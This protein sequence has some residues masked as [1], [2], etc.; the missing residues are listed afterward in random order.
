MHEIGL[1]AVVLCVLVL[2]CGWLAWRLSTG[3]R[4]VMRE[5][6]PRNQLSWR[7]SRSTAL[8][9]AKPLLLPSGDDATPPPLSPNFTVETTAPETTTG[10]FSAQLKDPVLWAAAADSA[11]AGMSILES[12]LKID[13][14][15]L[16]AI[17]F[18]TAQDLHGLADIHSY[19]DAHFSTVASQSAD[20]WFDRLTGYVAEQKAAT[21]FEQA[22]H[23]VQ[24]AP[25]SNQPVW[26]LL[27]DGHPVQIKEHL[28]G[29]KDFAVA[30][31]DIPVYTNLSD[32]AA[33]H[34]HSVHGLSVLDKDSIH[35]ATSNTIDGLD[36]TFD[37]GFHFP[38]I[39]L[40]FSAYRE[41][42]LLVAE[43]TTFE[44]ALVHVGMDVAAVGGGA[45]A[46][47]KLGALAGT[48]VPGP[49][50]VIGALLGS[51]VGGISGK[52][53]ST[54]ARRIPFYAARQKYNETIESA[55]QAIDGE[56]ANSQARVRELQQ[57]YQARFEAFRRRAESEARESI[58]AGLSAYERALVEFYEEFPRYLRD[59][60][61]QL[62]TEERDVLSTL[63][64]SGFAGV[65]LPG[66]ALLH[67]LA[68]KS[69]FRRARRVV[70][71]QKRQYE[72]LKLRDLESL[73]AGVQSILQ[74]FTF[75]LESLQ[76]KL[77]EFASH[78]EVQR[79]AAEA[80]KKS[81][82]S[83]VIQERERLIREFGSHV[84]R[85]HEGLVR[86]IQYWNGQIGGTR[87]E[88]RTQAAAVGIRI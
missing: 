20:G 7:V 55:Q 37:P 79:Q 14:Q 5:L 10:G 30:H 19:V 39:T 62:K 22:G 71:Q 47:A 70:A 74:D 44:R 9:E 81:A 2:Y 38:I 75:E 67:R 21:F 36:G 41:A 64:K 25:T 3:V 54:G 28:A 46:G 11:V 59:L 84:N 24:F 43:Q 29:A 26:D 85:M 66:E 45:L 52:I 4:R 77:A 27:V 57:D 80:I 31:P 72:K 51:I 82:M 48:I 6:P 17:E 42:K 1:L 68:V 15:V 60:I 13:P 87:D 18:S 49:G 76:G 65:I 83:D 58:K 16:H 69:W 35:A 33:I 8:V 32:A 40:G 56:I 78:L 50:N 63:P 88:L 23:H 73:N 53:L 12:A 34:E 61:E 86:T